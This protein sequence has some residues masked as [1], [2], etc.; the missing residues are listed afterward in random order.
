MIVFSNIIIDYWIHK[1]TNESVEFH[2]NDIPPKNELYYEL[3][4]D[5]MNKRQVCQF[6]SL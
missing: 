5:W 1:N 6:V 3:S 2:N 4:T